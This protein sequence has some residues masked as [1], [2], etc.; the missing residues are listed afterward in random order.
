M[1]SK[2]WPC[3]VSMS[4]HMADIWLL[5]CWAL[6][7]LTLNVELLSLQ[8]RISS[9]M[10]WTSQIRF[11]CLCR[12]FPC[13]ILNDALLFWKDSWS[14]SSR[15]P[16]ASAFSERYLGS[17]TDSR[18]YSVKLLPTNFFP[19]CLWVKVQKRWTI[20][21]TNAIRSFLFF[22]RRWRIWHRERACSRRSSIWSSTQ[23]LMVMEPLL[24]S[25]LRWSHRPACTNATV[26]QLSNLSSPA[27]EKVHF[28]HTAKF[29]S[30]LIS[31]N[32]NYTLQ[33][34]PGRS[35]LFQLSSD[36]ISYIVLVLKSS[37]CTHQVLLLTSQ[38][39]CKFFFVCLLTSFITHWLLI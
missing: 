29:I 18:V 37:L 8:S 26:T 19:P 35:K 13:N 16:A 5:C 21:K 30:H 15:A 3:G 14:L 24:F 25:A 23:L 32:A 34:S 20:M 17:K 7:S 28:Q 1:G 2:E 12:F 38:T 11:Y 36:C 22:S 27:A 31:E 9:S 33:V 39:H 10:V 4:R 6:T